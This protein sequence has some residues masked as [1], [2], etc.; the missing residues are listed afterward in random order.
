MTGD[1]EQ[2]FSM[3]MFVNEKDLYKAKAEYYQKLYNELKADRNAIL[4]EAIEVVNSCKS[5]WENECYLKDHEVSIINGI[6]RA[7]E[8]KKVI[9]ETNNK[10]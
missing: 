2:S 9:D 1:K 4:D 5:N 10:A 6:V 8:A 7:I 3:S